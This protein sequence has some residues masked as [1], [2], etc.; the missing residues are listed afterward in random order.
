MNTILTASSWTFCKS[1]AT[2]IWMLL[3]IDSPSFNPFMSLLSN[4]SSVAASVVLALMEFLGGSAGSS[5]IVIAL[6]PPV[7]ISITKTYQLVRAKF[8]VS[9]LRQTIQL[10]AGKLLILS[11]VISNPPRLIS[12][13]LFT[14]RFPFT[15]TFQASLQ[16]RSSAAGEQAYCLVNLMAVAEFIGNLDLEG[17]VS[18][19]D[20][21]VLPENGLMPIPVP[22]TLPINIGGRPSSH[23]ASMSSH[24]SA[25]SKDGSS[26]TTPVLSSSFTLRNRV[27]QHASALSSFANFLAVAQYALSSLKTLQEFLEPGDQYH[28][29]STAARAMQ[30][31]RR[32]GIMKA[33]EYWSGR[34]VVSIALA[35]SSDSNAIL[36]GGK[37]SIVRN[38]ALE[39]IVIVQNPYVFDLE[40]QSLSLST[41]G[42]PF[43]SNPTSLAPGGVPREFVIPLATEEEEERLTH[44]R[45]AALCEAGRFKYSG[46][47]NFPWERKNKS[48]NSGLGS[49]RSSKTMLFLECKVIPKQPLLRIRRTTVTHGALMLYDGEMLTF[50]DST[51]T[52][53]QQALAEG[54]LSVFETYETEYALIHRPVFSWIKNDSVA[55]APGRKVTLTIN[56]FG[57]HGRHNPRVL[58]LYP[59]PIPTPQSRF[60]SRRRPT[61]KLRALYALRRARA[62]SLADGPGF[63]YAFVDRGRDW[64]LGMTS[65]F[66]R[67]KA[68]WD[69]ECPCAHRRWLPPIRV[70]RRRRAESLGHLQLEIKCLDRPKRYCAHCRRTHIEIFVFRGHWN[71]TWRI[72]IR[73][74]LLRVAVQ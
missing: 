9:A 54:E 33:V 62:T 50:D 57:K 61:L 15:H 74:L 36:K 30:I 11:V 67:R 6:W 42:V 59:S 18:A 26:P 12:H 38:E 1:L 25:T 8:S 66:D 63:L 68:Q 32:R 40:L 28:L 31:A 29:Y 46:L 47:D 20:N 48:R 24:Y 56:C 34:P 64:K 43:E 27:E 44:K 55:I 52:P 41:S 69:K 73:P 70:S 14:Q 16:N 35:P 58:L 51:I 22:M 39:F 45:S 21:A 72:V 60:M 3:N 71:W 2:P 23:R 10:H 7:A 13:L 4:S 49:S 5:A 19:R 37:P 17:V 65:D 53:A